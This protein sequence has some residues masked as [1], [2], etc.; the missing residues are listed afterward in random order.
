MKHRLKTVLRGIIFSAVLL[1][2]VLHFDF[3]DTSTLAGLLSYARVKG[4]NV[5]ETRLID[6]V[7]NGEADGFRPGLKVEIEIAKGNLIRV[8]VIDHNEVNP[9]FWERPVTIIPDEIIKRQ[10]TKVD[11]VSGASATSYG[12]M[13]AVEDALSKATP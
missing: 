3:S 7:Y 13:A 4:I 10:S 12:I 5:K 9:R 1:S 6:G 11:A 2:A 8:D